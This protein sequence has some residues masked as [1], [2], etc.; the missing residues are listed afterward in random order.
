M[1]KIL[2]NGK[3]VALK[4]DALVD[5]SVPVTSPEEALQVMT[6]KHPKGRRVA[7]HFHVPHRRETNVLQECLVV[8]RGKLRV[9]FF[10]EDG[11][12]FA[13]VDLAKG[14]MCIT[15]FGSHGV[16]FLEDSEVIE[17]KNGPFID[18]KKTLSE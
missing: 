3:L 4:V 7:P 9:S 1:E 13:Q 16:E 12:A 5:G 2:H 8:I 17:I 10:G 6:L 14:E 15:L 11:A 18:D